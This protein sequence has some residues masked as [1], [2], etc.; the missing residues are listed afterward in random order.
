MIVD[1]YLLNWSETSTTRKPEKAE[2]TIQRSMPAITL[3]PARAAAI[4]QPHIDVEAI[5]PEA[6]W[7]AVTP[8]SAIKA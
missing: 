4:G 7:T 2:S 5:L 1:G 3:L 6:A 8:R